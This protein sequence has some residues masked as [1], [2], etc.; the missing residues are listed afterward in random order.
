V[1]LTRSSGR[2]CSA[3]ALDAGAGWLLMSAWQPCRLPLLTQS[4]VSPWRIGTLADKVDY[5]DIAN[6]CNPRIRRVQ[7]IAQ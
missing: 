5:D 4:I 1:T 6:I 3:R 7:L 2:P